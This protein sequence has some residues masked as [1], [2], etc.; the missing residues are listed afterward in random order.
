MNT[1]YQQLAGASVSDALSRLEADIKAQPGNADRRAAFVQ[2]LCLNANWTR[3]LTQLKSWA[4][5][6][7]QAQPTVTLLQQAIEGEQQ[8]AEVLAGRARPR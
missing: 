2:F 3:A 4:A 6:A 5:L 1:L 8:R 7:P